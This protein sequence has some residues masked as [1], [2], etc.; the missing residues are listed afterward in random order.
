MG[1]RLENIKS[2]YL[3]L[4][5]IALLF[6]SVGYQVGLNGFNAT[7]K[8][9]PFE[10]KITNGNPPPEVGVDFS[11]FWE[12][13][14]YLNEKSVDRPLNPQDLLYGAISGLAASLKDPYT[15]FLTPEQSSQ[16]NSSL[17]GH[18]EGIGAELGLKDGQLIV[19]A[20]LEGSPAIRAGIKSGDKIMKIDGSDTFGLTLTDAV[21]KIRG[22]QGSV[23]ALFLQR[24]SDDPFELKL[25]RDKILVSSLKVEKKG[26]GVYYV[27]LSRFGDDTNADWDKVVDEILTEGRPKSVVLDLRGNAGGYLESSV[28]VASEFIVESKIVTSERRS[29]GLKRDHLVSR[30]GRLA[31]IPV[32]VIINQGSASAAE[33]L[34]A[35]LRDNNGAK[36]VGMKSFGKGSVQEPIDL[37]DG[38]NLHVTIAKWLTPKGE[39]IHGKGLDPDIKVDITEEEMEDE[40]DP[41]LGKALEL[42][43]GK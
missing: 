26:E 25:T 8:A 1:V 23:V 19:V 3:V 9:R 28:Y 5:F 24:G 18:Y 11:L 17:N 22:K 12:A 21:S 39:E 16:L 7:V 35:A 30:K 37:S 40:K 27:R 36:V 10:I 14:R 15:A 31:G 41:Q 33:I 20:P 4:V 38:S 29:D 43:A 2:T 32:V 13:W 34:A 6:F 42:A